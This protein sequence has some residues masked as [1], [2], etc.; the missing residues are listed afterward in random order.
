M[1]FVLCKHFSPH[2][3]SSLSSL[4]P[5]FNPPPQFHQIPKLALAPY[6]SA[7][8]WSGN[9]MNISTSEISNMIRTETELYLL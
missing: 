9:Y 3:C 1:P 4:N 2:I 8:L 5:L 6:S 7:T